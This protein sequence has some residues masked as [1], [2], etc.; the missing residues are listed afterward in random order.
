M[1][2]AFRDERGRTGCKI[3]VANA[4]ASLSL[5]R[6]WVK[7]PHSEIGSRTAQ[8]VFS[9][10]AYRWVGISQD[11]VVWRHCEPNQITLGA[12]QKSGNAW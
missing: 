10:C 9:C 12:R 6:H 11:D 5:G 8:F 2:I 7:M 1:F 4:H 3:A